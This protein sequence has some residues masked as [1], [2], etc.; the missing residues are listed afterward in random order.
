MYMYTYSYIYI[1]IYIAKSSTIQYTDPKQNNDEQ[2]DNVLEFNLCATR[3]S[4]NPS[5]LGMFCYDL[6]KETIHIIYTSYIYIYIYICISYLMYIYIYIH[7]ISLLFLLKKM[8]Y[9]SIFLK[10]SNLFKLSI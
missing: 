8:V 4:T 1:Y 7:D 2:C 10:P 3:E 5:N 9:L 6:R